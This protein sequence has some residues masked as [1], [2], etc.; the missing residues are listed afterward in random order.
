MTIGGN[1]RATEINVLYSTRI[2]HQQL[3]KKETNVGNKKQ[4]L[5][6][7]GFITDIQND[8]SNPWLDYGNIIRGPFHQEG[9]G[10]IQRRGTK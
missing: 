3:Q 9:I 8:P 2:A 10:V 4:V 6:H 7:V 5:R 1:F